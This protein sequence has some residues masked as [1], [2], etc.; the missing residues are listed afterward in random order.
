MAADSSEREEDNGPEV[1]SSG[2]ILESFTESKETRD[3][4]VNL[5]TTCETLV[6][7]EVCT[8]RF[9]VIMDKYQEQP[10]LLDSHLEWMLDLLLEIVRDKTSSPLLFHLAFKFL[11]IISKVRGYKIFIRL[12]PHEVVDVHPVLEMIRAQNPADPE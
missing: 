9:I 6:T 10:H 2:N 7:R 5:R 11:Y 12:F 3:L 1:V 4:I 8:Q